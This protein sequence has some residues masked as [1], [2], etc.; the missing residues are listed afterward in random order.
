MYTLTCIF[1]AFLHSLS[2]PLPPLTSIVPFVLPTGLQV[3]WSAPSQQTSDF[4]NFQ[5]TAEDA[6]GN[7]QQVLSPT[8]PVNINQLDPETPYVV[9]VETVSGVGLG[10][11]YSESIPVSAITSKYTKLIFTLAMWQK[12]LADDI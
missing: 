1:V 5:I 4:T 9:R 2:V 8:S 12:A 11:T 6:V 3:A 7:R 10:T